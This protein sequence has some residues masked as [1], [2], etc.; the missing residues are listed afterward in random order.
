MNEAVVEPVVEPVVETPPSGLPSDQPPV[1]AYDGFALSDDQKALFKEGKLNGR[2]GS[3]DEVLVKL[4]EAEDFK[5]QYGRD[6]KLE[7]E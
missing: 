2:F 6:V 5:S 7:G 4:K 1:E 3:L